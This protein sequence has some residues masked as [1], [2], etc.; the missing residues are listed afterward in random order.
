MLTQHR[1]IPAAMTLE[2]RLDRQ[3]V[4]FARQWQVECDALCGMQQAIAEQALTD[5]L[6]V[7]A[8]LM[9]TEFKPGAAQASTEKGIGHKGL[10]VK[11]ATSPTCAGAVLR[12]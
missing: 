10:V 7:L 8:L 9:L 1:Q 12:S 6:G 5:G 4:K 11:G 2:S 3:G